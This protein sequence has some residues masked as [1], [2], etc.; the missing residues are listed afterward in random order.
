MK[1]QVLDWLD[2]VPDLVLIFDTY[3]AVERGGVEVMTL[4]EHELYHAVQAN[5]EFG[6]Q[7]TNKQTGGLIFTMRG[8]R[9]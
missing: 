8:P 5:E 2:Q 1:C 6:T 7:R 9:R 4:V 3:Y